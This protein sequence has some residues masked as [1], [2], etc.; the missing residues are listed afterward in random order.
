[1]KGL[2]IVLALVVLLAS[3]IFLLVGSSAISGKGVENTIQHSREIHAS[4][5]KA[6]AFVDMFVK[7]N[8]RLPTNTE[9]EAWANSFPL[10]P[11]T[12]N[13]MRIFAGPFDAETVRSNGPPPA[14]AY[15][16]VYWRG[17]WDES[18]VSWS[19]R[20]S[21]AF[22]DASYFLFGSRIA[23]AFIMFVVA[24]LLI[25]CAWISWPRHRA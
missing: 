10:Q 24:A 18:Y 3:A 2:R 17:E 11:Y 9:F 5:E 23:E 19:K 8:G 1:M 12:P 16:L 4:F 22:D 6:T 7:Q 20:S 14:N 15:M 21:L 25:G 13:G